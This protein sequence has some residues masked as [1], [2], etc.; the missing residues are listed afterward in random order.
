MPKAAHAAVEKKKR[1]DLRKFTVK[2]S[3]CKE[4]ALFAA[5]PSKSRGIAMQPA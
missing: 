1:M 4:K 2:K 3:N 5:D